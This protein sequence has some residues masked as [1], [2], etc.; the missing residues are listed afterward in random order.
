M[1]W[2]ALFLCFCATLAGAQFTPSAQQV[3]LMAPQLRAFAGSDANFESLASGL[4]LGQTVTLSSA[5]ENGRLEIAT[6]TAAA[7]LPP[8]DTA[9]L[10]EA[11]RQRLIAQGVGQPRAAQIAVALMG[12]TLVTPS[13]TVALSPMIGAADPKQP[14]QVALTFFSG[15]RDNFA[16]LSTGLSQGSTITLAPTNSGGTPVTFTPPGGPMSE[17]EASQ[18]LNLAAAL[19]A[20]QGIY[21]PTPEQV[22]AAIVG[23]RVTL[24]DG[25][26]VLLRGVMEGR[27]APAAAPPT[28]QTAGEGR[29]SDSPAVGRTSDTSRS[30]QTSASPPGQTS[31]RPGGGFT[32]DRPA[33][34]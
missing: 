16:R 9:R 25:R 3:Y 4:S 1:R 2:I 28:S 15:S 12:G 34:K 11:A 29:V 27:T 10:L 21:N 23:G 13:G 5:A 32:S 18:T 7:G 31:S 30:G 22:R 26:S 33:K 17:A 14:L 6:F 8:G 19:L 24:A 20:A